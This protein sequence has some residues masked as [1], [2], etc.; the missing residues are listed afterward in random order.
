VQFLHLDPDQIN[1]DPCRL[2][3]LIRIWNPANNMSSNQFLCPEDQ[4]LQHS[5]KYTEH[6]IKYGTHQSVKRFRPLTSW[7]A[8]YFSSKAHTAS[9]IPKK[10]KSALNLICINVNPDLVRSKLFGLIG[11]KLKEAKS[12]W[13]RIQTLT[14]T[15]DIKKFKHFYT[16]HTSKQ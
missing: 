2:R 5:F 6:I 14:Q 8:Q 9:S 7:K 11:S 15:F 10:M 4:D 13:I 16:K 12:F 1:A 3:I